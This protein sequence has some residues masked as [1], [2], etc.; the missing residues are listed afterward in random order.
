MRKTQTAFIDLN[1][2][3]KKTPLQEWREQI[4]S[5]TQQGRG[6][7]TGQIGG[8]LD[9]CPIALP[10]APVLN[11]NLDDIL[12][13]FGL[14][15]G[16]V[17]AQNEVVLYD[18]FNQQPVLLANATRVT[19]TSFTLPTH[20]SWVVDVWFDSLHADPETMWQFTADTTITTTASLD[21]Q[22]IVQ[23][24]YVGIAND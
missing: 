2:P 12:D 18:S 15:V 22:V 6:P 19:G 5:R 13:S 8:G 4:E 21:S 24:L 20:A 10:G 23:V 3:R 1:I 11:I 16:E 17:D 7:S 9:Y 14:E